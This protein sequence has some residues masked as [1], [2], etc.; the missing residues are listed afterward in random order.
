MANSISLS[1]VLEELRR[2]GETLYGSRL[3]GLYLFGSYARGEQVPD[4]D[5]DVLF[6][7]N[8]YERYFTEIQHMGDFVSRLSLKY[9]ITISTVFVRES[10]WLHSHW[11]FLEN[12]RREAIAA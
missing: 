4:S 8:D 2:G 7:L 11:P 6:V 1:K 10:E 3:K 5:L 12:V 9:G